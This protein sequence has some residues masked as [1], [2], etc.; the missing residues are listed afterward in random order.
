MSA[1]SIEVFTSL[2][3]NAVDITSLI[4]SESLGQPFSAEVNLVCDNSELDR[5]SVL[6]QPLSIR[7]SARDDSDLWLSGIVCRFESIGDIDSQAHY[8]ARVVSSYGLLELVGGCRI[9]QDLSVL[10]II[11][12]VLEGHGLAGSIDKKTSQ[13]YEKRPYCVQYA[14][15]DFRFLQRLM[16]E[17][18][19]YYFF[20]YEK[21]KHTMILADDLST[22]TPPPAYET[23]EYR[24][25][26]HPR[27]R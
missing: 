16:E 21:G 10:E 24:S 12:K 19:I 23:I 22:H 1:F 11:D 18:G 15:S 8:R 17:E 3:D 4:W 25:Q 27:Y 14:E 6:N 9:F 26:L 20:A 2:G 13:T 7:L 5:K